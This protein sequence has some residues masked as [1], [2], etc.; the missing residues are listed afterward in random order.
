M[1]V[2]MGI[3]G[4]FQP[5]NDRE[6]IWNQG[7]YAIPANSSRSELEKDIHEDRSI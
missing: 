1:S 3:W 4:A 5:W 6:W 2:V 7:E